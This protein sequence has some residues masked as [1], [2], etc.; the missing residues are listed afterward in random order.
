MPD[1]RQRERGE[2]T[3]RAV[4]WAGA[5]QKA[6][7]RPRADRCHQLAHAGYARGEAQ[8]KR[9]RRRRRHPPVVAF[10]CMLCG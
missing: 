2:H 7:Q 9:E 1:Q 3:R 8:C 4:A 6:L 10:T 5:Q